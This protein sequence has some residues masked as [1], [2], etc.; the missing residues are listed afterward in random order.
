MKRYWQRFA[1]WMDARNI[2]ERILIFG[3]TIALAA[4]LLDTLLVEPVVAERKR[5]AQATS[6]DQA[7]IR[8]MVEQVQVLGRSK[9]ADPDLA[10]RAKLSEFEGKLGELQREV[11]AQSAELVPPEKMAAV[12]EKILAG[13]TRLQFVEVKTLP[14]VPISL[15]REPVK[16]EAS[17]A[18]APKSDAAAGKPPAEIY[19]HGVEITM[20]GS[21]LDLVSYLAAIESQ[22]VRMFW[23]KVNLSVTDYPTITLKVM[24][25]T[26]SLEKV[27]LTV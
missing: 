12:L 2:R 7:E 19:R 17:K 16:A 27:W 14:R 21:Y 20:R 13:S 9:G 24:V 25:Y 8:K 4:V 11:T 1:S 15:E 23:D 18:P 3:A 10:L 22:P 5:I 26:I 6:N